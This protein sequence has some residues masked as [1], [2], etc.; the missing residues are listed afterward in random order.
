MIAKLIKFEPLKDGSISITLTAT[1]IDMHQL[2]DLYLHEVDIC[3]KNEVVETKE[4][5][6]IKEFTDLIVKM[7]WIKDFMIKEKESENQEVLI[8]ALENKRIDHGT[9]N[10]I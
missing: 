3:K 5:N 8:P 1:D 4:R 2:V 6:I 10:H 9:N 7:F